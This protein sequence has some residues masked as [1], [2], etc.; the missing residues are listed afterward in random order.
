MEHAI[1][2][3]VAEHAI[4]R[5]VAEHAISRHVAQAGK[6]CD[7]SFLRR[8]E[9]QT[10]ERK[11]ARSAAG[12]ENGGS[13]EGECTFA[14][15]INVDARARRARTAAEMSTGDRERR[16]KVTAIHHDCHVIVTAIHYDCHRDCHVIAIV[17][18]T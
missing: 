11:A 16:E 9:K 14:P 13:A 17:I 4:S 7:D 15:R 5:H 6:R 12:K 3:H 10:A 1:S 8:L 2:R 18:A